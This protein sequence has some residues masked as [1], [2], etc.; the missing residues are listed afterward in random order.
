MDFYKELFLSEGYEKN[1]EHTLHR[2]SKFQP[3][4]AMFL[5]VI[6]E[7]GED[8]LEILPGALLMQEHYRKQPMKVV[9]VTDCQADAL[10]FIEQITKK[11]YDETGTADVKSFLLER[12]AD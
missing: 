3:S 1:R 6:K 5:V 9:A 4:A 11:V 8:Q 7:E 12:F 2:L 10:L